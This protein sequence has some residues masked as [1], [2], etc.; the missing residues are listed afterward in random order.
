MN[1]Y[2]K[3]KQASDK[4]VTDLVYDEWKGS[5]FDA[6]VNT[7]IYRIYQ[8]GLPAEVNKDKIEKRV[9]Q[10]VKELSSEDGEMQLWH[11]V[12][13]DKRYFGKIKNAVKKRYRRKVKEIERAKQGPLQINTPQTPEIP[14]G[15]GGGMGGGMLM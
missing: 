4:S 3:I 2:V 1:W 12:V 13:E 10:V 14:Q 6:N 15:G 7:I 8:I 5:T 9:S 11:K